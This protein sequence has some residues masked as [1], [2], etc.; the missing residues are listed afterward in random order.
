MPFANCMI[1]IKV[2][3]GGKNDLKQHSIAEKHTR[4]RKSQNTT[5]P[6]TNFFLQ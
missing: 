1:D 5:A 6:V 3:H 2:D 4:P